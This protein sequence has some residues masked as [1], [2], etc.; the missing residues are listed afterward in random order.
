VTGWSMSCVHRGCGQLLGKAIRVFAALIT[1]SLVT[2]PDLR[3][4]TFRQESVPIGA[5]VYPKLHQTIGMQTPGVPDSLFSAVGAASRSTFWQ[6]GIE[7]RVAFIPDPRWNRLAWA[8]DGDSIRVKGEFG[9]GA[10][11]FSQPGWTAV[12]PGPGVAVADAA[13]GRVCIYL[14]EKWSGYYNGYTLRYRGALADTAGFRVPSQ[15]TWDDN[16]TPQDMGQDD[17][18]WVLDSS[19]AR[20]AGYHVSYD[21][22]DSWFVMSPYVRIDTRVFGNAA[23]P[24]AVVKMRTATAA[25]PATGYCTTELAVYDKAMRRF[26]VYD[27]PRSAGHIQN[28]AGTATFRYVDAPAEVGTITAMSADAWGNLLCVEGGRSRLVKLSRTFELLE[29]FGSKGRGPIG[30][31][32]LWHPVAIQPEQRRLADG[33]KSLGKNA[34]LTEAWSDSSGVQQ[35]RLGLDVRDLMLWS[36]PGVA[37]VQ[38]QFKTTDAATIRVDVLN[39]YGTRVRTISSNAELVPGLKGLLWDGR[40]DDGTYAPRCQTYTI[41]NRSII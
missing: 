35:I 12:G 9:S 21:P 15:V 16:G 37:E 17:I 30:T 41:T 1:L 3:A 14:Y 23:A 18:V 38:G 10:D 40:K 4:E 27:I 31:S 28:V 20:I 13:N 7:K 39:Q 25:D 2:G 11:K 26:V 29:F 8:T 19:S 33:R 36:T 34:I 24:S 22:G 6:D 32:Q 5:G